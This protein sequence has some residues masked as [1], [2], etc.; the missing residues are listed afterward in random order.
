MLTKTRAGNVHL[1]NSPH[2]LITS[3]KYLCNPV[4]I[5]TVNGGT[6]DQACSPTVNISSDSAISNQDLC[7]P[8]SYNL[9]QTS[10]NQS[11]VFKYE[12]TAELNAEVDA[13]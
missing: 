9:L 6:D 2:M 4:A 7:S 8:Q 10:H 3:T 1:F 11:P 13:I 12:E 5:I